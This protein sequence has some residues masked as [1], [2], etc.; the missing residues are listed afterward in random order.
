MD[1]RERERT[2]LLKRS[3]REII[4]SLNHAIIIFDYLV[5]INVAMIC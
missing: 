2:F 4:C 1:R 5:Y 3:V